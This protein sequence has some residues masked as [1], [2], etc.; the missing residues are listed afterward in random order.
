MDYYE[1]KKDQAFLVSQK[2]FIRKEGKLLLL[3]CPPWEKKKTWNNNWGL[4]GGYIEFD[5]DP[6]SGL[7]REVKEETNLDIRV[8][9]PVGVSKVN[10][11]GFIFKDGS[12]RTLTIIQ[13]GYDVE[14]LGGE[15]KLSEEHDDY[16]WVNSSE[17]NEYNIGPDS[18]GLIKSY[19]EINGF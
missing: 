7:I 5:E 16:V 10:Y 17:L 4:P 15:I 13:I 6:A 19:L 12:V 1:L 9:N 11:D 8:G 2:A 3:H 18:E 14:I